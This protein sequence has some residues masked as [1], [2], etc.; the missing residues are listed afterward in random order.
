MVSE[1][2]RKLRDAISPEIDFRVNKRTFREFYCFVLCIYFLETK[3]GYSN[4][5]QQKILF[6]S[7]PA[8]LRFT[9]GSNLR[10]LPYVD[11][12]DLN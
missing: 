8:T 3:C 11:K 10:L 6:V 9:V 7:R 12:A 1:S 4:A 2:L 5:W